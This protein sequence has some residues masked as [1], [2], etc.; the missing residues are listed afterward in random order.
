M[1]IKGIYH[2]VDVETDEV[3]YIGKDSYINH[4]KRH[5]DHKMQ[6][7]YN[8]QRFNTVLQNNPDR[9]RYEIVCAGN[10]SPELL[11]TLEVNEI[12]EFKMLHN[13]ELPKFNFTDGGESG[14]TVSEETRKRLSESHKGENNPNYGK[15]RP[16]L[17][18]RFAGK[19]NPFYGKHHSEETKKK[20]SN[21]KKGKKKSIEDMIKDSEVKN[22][23]GYFRVSKIKWKDV[24]Q[25][26]VWCY[27]YYDEDGN[28]KSIKSVDLKKVEAK[29]K[30][31]GLTWMEL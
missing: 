15:K 9:Y 5:S 21:S 1:S 2:Y 30:E 23:T 26:F 8:K 14:F 13:G 10:Y 28:K 16:D 11:A 4:S 17:S 29:V 19:N 12:A 20:I 22:T 3:V 18:K 24:T 7:N 27:Q 31:K 6:S 25:G